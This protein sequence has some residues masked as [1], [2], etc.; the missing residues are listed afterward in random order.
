LL[1]S[2]DPAKRRMSGSEKWPSSLADRRWFGRKRG[3]DVLSNS[4]AS[5][6]LKYAETGKKKVSKRKR[7]ES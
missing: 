5:S 7:Y 4:D 2:D 3:N 6:M 1:G